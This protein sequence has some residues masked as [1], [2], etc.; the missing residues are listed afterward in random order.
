[1]IVFEIIG[2]INVA[3]LI[4]FAAMGIAYHRI[5]TAAGEV[6]TVIAGERMP[7]IQPLPIPTKNQSGLRRIL[8]WMFEIR[9]WQLLDNWFFAWEGGYVVIPKGFEFDGASIPRPF[10]FFLSP[11]GLLLIPGLIH[12]Y[13]YRFG[14]LWKIAD[15]EM[16]RFGTDEKRRYWDRIFKEIGRA[17][18]GFAVIDWIA[19]LALWIFGGGAWHEWADSRDAGDTRPILTPAEMKKYTKMIDIENE[20]N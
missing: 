7:R 18:N 13:G 20:K 17:I 4:L 15:G 10:W 8:V 5:K 14:F 2:L 19:W 1:M 9:R 6:K 16:I 3:V 12:D 11:V